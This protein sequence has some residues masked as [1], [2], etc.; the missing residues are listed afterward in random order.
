MNSTNPSIRN[1]GHFSPFFLRATI[2]VGLCL[3][4][5]GTGTRSQAGNAKTAQQA[6]KNVQVLNDVPADDLVPGMQFVAASL[7][8]ECDFCHIRDAF[9]KDDEKTKHTSRRIM[10]QVLNINYLNYE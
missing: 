1:K 3:F 7:G 8:V 4:A 6:F 5:V 2:A 9:E 10:H